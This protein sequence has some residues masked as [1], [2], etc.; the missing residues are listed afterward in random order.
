MVAFYSKGGHKN[1][2]LS[3][4]IQPLDLTSP[5]QA[6][7]VAFLHTLTGEIDPAVGRPPQLP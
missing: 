4:A 1:P 6:D 3:K 5:E 2:W 7:L